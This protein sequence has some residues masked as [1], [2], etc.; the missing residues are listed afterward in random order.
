L[1]SEVEIIGVHPIEA[2]E[3]CYL[4]EIAVTDPNDKFDW[5][6]VIQEKP[7][8]PPDNWQVAYDEQSVDVAEGQS[9]YVFFFHY[10]DL[11]RLLRT[12]FGEVALPEPTP[13]PP[14]LKG[15]KYC[16]PG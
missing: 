7:G 4:I 5:N 11:S 3:P 9:R 12:S 10:L 13:V 14:H 16:P 8:Q 15:I 1:K 6:D 2:A